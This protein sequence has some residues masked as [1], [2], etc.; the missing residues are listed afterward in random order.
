MNKVVLDIETIGA[1]FESLDDQSKNYL[2]KYAKDEKEK[3][4]IKNSLAFSPLTGEIVSIGMFNPITKKG[5][6]YYQGGGNDTNFSNE[7][8]FYEVCAEREMLE[9]FWKKIKNYSQII[10]FNGRTF[11]GPFLHLRSAIQKV[12]PTR[13]LVPYRYD[14]RLHCDL[15]D[16]LTFYGATRRFSLDFYSK[17]FNL[18]TSKIAGIDGSLVSEMF[19]EGRQREI[20]QYCAADVR[21]T[22]ELFEYWEKYLKF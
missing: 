11:D 18:K 6:V 4:Y 22:A 12:K 7:N 15:L 21:V 10:T 2:L 5:L 13:N 19:Q 1:D 9:N 3:E 14:Y 8:I 17:K 20:A 16:Q